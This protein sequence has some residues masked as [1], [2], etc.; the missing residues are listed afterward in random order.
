ML[1]FR[2]IARNSRLSR[3]QV[4]EVAAKFPEVSFRVE[5]LA[6]YGDRHQHISLLNGE[7]PAD[8]FTRELDEALIEGRADLAIHSAKDLPYPMDARLEVVALFPPFD[9]SDSL[10][11]RSHLT[12]AQLLAGS[13]VGTSSPMRRRELQALRPDLKVVGIRG[14]IEERV[15]Q[16]REGEF[17][18]AIVATC[19]LKRLG[20]VDEISEVLPFETHPLQG[21]LAVTARRGRNDLK[22]LLKRDDVLHRQ[23]HVVLAGFGPGDPE[24]LTV[25]AVKALRQADIIFYD[26]LIGKQYLD[27]L[28]AEKIYVGKRNGLH[29]TEQDSINR[30]LLDAARKGKE[31]VRLKGGD[32]MIFAHGGE[33]IEFLQSNLV[34]VKVIPGIT[35]A[36]ALA[37]STKVSLTH[38]DISSGVSFV[39]GH[40][41]Y[42]IVPNTETVV[43][44]MGGKSIGR[45]G[46]SLHA[47]GWPT[48]TPVLLVHNVSLPDEQTF[49]T[50]VGQLAEGNA[51]DYPTPVI[52]LVGD[53]ARLRRQTASTVRRTL[54][55]GLS[56]PEPDYIHTPLIEI[57]PVEFELPDT[58]GF[59]YLLFTSRHAV[60]C[61][62]QKGKAAVAAQVVSIGPATTEELK[63]FG[64]TDVFQ[65][66]KDDSYGVLDYFSRQ[67]SGR[68]VLFP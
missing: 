18:A 57:R 40:A 9:Q 39:N 22:E 10:V 44:Y 15:R 8:M 14:C 30:L 37:A 11:S 62:F 29:H 24:L 13:T 52:A 3:L 6:S 53:V 60:R 17:D 25:K 47:E 46:Q 35:T 27:T 21:Y 34:D 54:Y 28:T 36:S 48:A 7:A 65:T 38:R 56:C 63:L 61:W 45:I 58:N 16:V 64:V 31:V 33:E 26:D 51:T 19:A 20:M 32:P 66:E 43:Y 41:A 12:L 50:T 5:L 2:V 68:K 55:T 1:E 4:E 42:P 59:D 49:E 67:P 23:G